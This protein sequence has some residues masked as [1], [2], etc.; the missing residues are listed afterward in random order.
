MDF[1]WKFHRGDL[2][3]CDDM[4]YRFNAGAFDR[5]PAGPKFDDSSWRD[6]DLP[7]DFVIE[8]KFSRTQR[9]FEKTD[10]PSKGGRA[11][12][13]L[14]GY[15]PVGV[16]WYR[17]TFR[18]PGSDIGRI[19][20]VEFDG[21]YRDSAVW[22]NGHYLGGHLSGYTG[23][24]FDITDV[25][26]YGGTNVLAV[27]ADAREYEIW[28]Y[29]GGGIYRHAWLVKTD[30]LRVP[31]HGT[32]VRTVVKRK[33]GK[34]LA[35]IT[36]QTK[37][38]N[39]A[40]SP[41]KC[42][43]ISTILGPDGRKAGAGSSAARIPAGENA[44]ITQTIDLP[45]P[46]LWSV[47]DPQ[48]YRLLS[49]IRRGRDVVDE[50]E[51]TFGIRTFRFDPDRGFYLNGKRMK[52][53]GANAH[54]DHAGV[55][56]ALPDRLHAFRVERLK[57]MG[58]NAYRTAHQ[59]PAPELL[60]ACDRLGMLVVSE[61]RFPGSS[62]ESLGQLESMVLRDRNHP[63][64][65]VWLLANEEGRMQATDTGARVMRTM[66]RAVRRIDP[67]RPVTAAMNNA[68]Q[69]WGKGFSKVIDVQGCN[70][71]WDLRKGGVEDVTWS[72]SE[73]PKLYDLY[74]RRHPKHPMLVTEAFVTHS[75]RG[76]YHADRRKGYVSAYERV[77]TEGCTT[78]EFTWGAVATRP[79]LSGVLIWC[80]FDY[81]G[82]PDSNPRCT[83]N[84]FGPLDLC[85]FAK[86]SFYYWKAWWADEPLVHV[87][88]HWNWREG[89]TIDVWCHSNCD[90]VELLLNGRSLGRKPVTPLRHLE[91]RVRYRPGTLLAIG[92]RGGKE[93]ARD[94]VQTTG[95]PSAIR[96]T[97]DHATW[98]SRRD[99]V[100]RGASTLRADNHDVAI[101]T[102]AVVDDAGRIVPTG[103]NRLT[104]K[105]G[106]GGKIIGVG[107]GDPADTDPPKA[108][109]RRAFNGL[110]QVII[111][112]PCKPAD[113]RLTATA[114][115]LRSAR[116]TLRAARCRAVPFVPSVQA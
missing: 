54:Q 70:Y 4:K 40:D 65:I 43:L 26:N 64:V 105:V 63:S 80:G 74:H 23:F 2:A 104:F 101:V 79:F 49:T 82:E 108:L 18:V 50:Y 66:R 97:P 81:S 19:L 17:K 11:A 69:T 115:G 62:P 15:L 102:A 107:N 116:I 13:A 20:R 46:A 7:H 16:G 25:V 21:V 12:H 38:S 67:T 88:P 68:S 59:P 27:R 57:E 45:N 8:G 10:P 73:N 5:G 85:G 41:A 14:H 110:C 31:P 44:E 84:N 30:P 56:V 76:I 94:E 61:H 100:R 9:T 95:K 77:G 53:T 113:M 35:T 32:F 37:L 103:G 93:A 89:R 33:D 109:H 36:V 86:D 22:V 75:T 6:V 78:D 58:C 111:Q 91:W 1:G 106:G 39:A 92:Y 72:G 52:L 29:T 55:G 51:T 71:A 28:S 112:A 24:G 42:R 87:F 34:T 96:L 60:D 47:D 90:E 48:C 98:S 3:V 114:A 83:S 99:R